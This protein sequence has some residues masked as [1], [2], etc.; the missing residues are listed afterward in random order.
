M[1]EEG[2]QFDPILLTADFFDNFFAK[3]FGRFFA[4]FFANFLPKFLVDFLPFVLSGN[5]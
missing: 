2:A 1:K 4:K 5:H 3:I